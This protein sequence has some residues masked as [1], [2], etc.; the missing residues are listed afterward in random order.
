[1]CEKNLIKLFFIQEKVYIVGNI[2][3]FYFPVSSAVLCYFIS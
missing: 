2:T 3:R 1:M